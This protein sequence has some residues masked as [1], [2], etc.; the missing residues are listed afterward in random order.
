MAE[1]AA[2]LD[3]DIGAAEAVVDKALTYYRT[4]L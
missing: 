2:G 3:G 1:N 4:Q